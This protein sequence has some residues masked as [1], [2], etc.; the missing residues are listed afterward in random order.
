MD[1]HLWLTFY[2]VQSHHVSKEYNSSL[3]SLASP[4]PTFGEFLRK[5]MVSLDR[6]FCLCVLIVPE[7]EMTYLTFQ[8]SRDSHH[9]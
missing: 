3:L 1:I 6:K 4:H 5:E 8:T 9:N 2:L 7:I